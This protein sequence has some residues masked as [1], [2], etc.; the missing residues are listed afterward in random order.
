MDK[1]VLKF[2][3]VYFELEK[4]YDM[5][6]INHAAWLPSFTIA[7]RHKVQKRD[8][9]QLRFEKSVVSALV[10]FIGDIESVI[11]TKERLEKILLH[12]SLDVINLT[13]ALNSSCASN[14]STTSINDSLLESESIILPSSSPTPNITSQVSPAKIKSDSL[15]TRMPQCPC[16]KMIAVQ[17]ATLSAIKKLTETV[18][19]MRKENRKL[20]KVIESIKPAGS[21]TVSN[22]LH[23]S[24]L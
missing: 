15:N 11:Q 13:A 18:T 9:I 12:Q 21:S 16:D 22:F 19:D 5:I 23:Q 3:L 10:V 20:R 4:K 24:V 17:D 6:S 14:R 1:Y 2:F 7:E 8:V